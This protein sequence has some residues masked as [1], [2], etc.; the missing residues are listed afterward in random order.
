MNL[1]SIVL[2]YMLAMSVVTFFVFMADKQKAK[3]NAWRIRE[4]T[5]IL[6]SFLGGSVG[7]MFGMFALRHKTKHISF[8]ILI[9]L[10]LVLHALLLALLIFR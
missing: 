2:I 7:A 5:L 6:L 9:P 8:L 10:S 1:L 4:R 3:N